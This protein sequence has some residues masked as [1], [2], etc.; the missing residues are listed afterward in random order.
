MLGETE[1]PEFSLAVTFFSFGLSS[2]FLKAGVLASAAD[3]PRNVTLPCLLQRKEKMEGK[4]F[5][6]C[7]QE[8]QEGVPL[9][10]EVWVVIYS[11]VCILLVIVSKSHQ[12]E[13]LVPST[14]GLTV[15]R[16][17]SE[18]DTLWLLWVLPSCKAFL[19]IFFK[20]LREHPP[21][22]PLSVSIPNDTPLI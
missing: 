4:T 18:S 15:N 1:P 8:Q 19:K 7:V 12:Q 14:V 11:N 3:S 16:N 10:L 17:L 5:L 9:D 2:H 22:N 13:S 6:L 20:Y 21:C